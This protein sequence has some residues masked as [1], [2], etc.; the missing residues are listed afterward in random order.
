MK[1]KPASKSKGNGFPVAI[2]ENILVRTVTMIQV[3]RLV[4]VGEHE[5]T[6]EDAAWV[7]DT[8]RFATMLATGKAEEVEPF[9]DGICFVGRGAIVDGCPWRHP[10]LRETK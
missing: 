9:P 3:G 7:A 5:L 2:G 10:L 6:L 8:G 4:A 1:T